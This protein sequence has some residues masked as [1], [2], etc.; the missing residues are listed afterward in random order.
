MFEGAANEHLAPK[1]VRENIQKLRAFEAGV[2]PTQEQEASMDEPT[3]PE[4]KGFGKSDTMEV[5]GT[6]KV[7]AYQTSEQYINENRK[8]IG[9]VVVGGYHE[10]E[11]IEQ[12]VV[13][14]SVEETVVGPT[15]TTEVPVEVPTE[16]PVEEPVKETVD[17]PVEVSVEQPVEES[18]V[19]TSVKQESTPVTLTKD[20]SLQDFVEGVQEPVQEPVDLSGLEEKVQK[21]EMSLEDY[22]KEALT[23]EDYAQYRAEEEA[24]MKE[25]LPL[26]FQYSQEKLAEMYANMDASTPEEL[27]SAAAL[28]AQEVEPA[29]A[30][31]GV[32]DSYFL[33]KEA[34]S[35]ANRA[36]DEDDIDD[37]T[38]LIDEDVSEHQEMSVNEDL[39]LDLAHQVSQ[40]KQDMVQE[41]PFVEETGKDPAV[42]AE[43]ASKQQRA[44]EDNKQKRDS[45]GE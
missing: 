39:R 6:P 9:N 29:Y 17:T 30:S 27:V 40:D 34:E 25:G 1:V 8:G 14:E 7:S 37:T 45:L 22:M 20:M 12:P 5:T 16:T 43:E 18:V 42:I 21:G 3:A 13:E 23:E 24:K 32:E 36:D 10:R 31:T 44:K 26:A 28:A 33:R 19:E 4:L 2:E 15:E 35:E 11:V 41:P 38:D